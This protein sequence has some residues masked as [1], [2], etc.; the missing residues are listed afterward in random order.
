MAWLA[1]A[2]LPSLAACGHSEGVASGAG[3]EVKLDEGV[4]HSFENVAGRRNYLLQI[5]A[6]SGGDAASHLPLVIY[7]HGCGRTVETAVIST[8]WSALAQEKGF[9][10]VYPEQTDSGC[11]T[12]SD[13]AH[14]HRDVGEPSIIAGITQE[15]MAQ[16][17]I[18]P[19]RVFVVGTSAGGYMA[20]IMGVTYPEL[21]A[22]V[23]ILAGGPYG[24]GSNSEPDA[25]GSLSYAEMGPRAR[26]MPVFIAQSAND[27][28]NPAGAAELALQQWLG[29]ADHADDSS[30]NESVSRTP[31]RQENRMPEQP[32][33]PGSG[34][35]CLSSPPNVCPGGA[36]GFQ[37]HYPY[38]VRYYLDAL[39]QPLI[40]FW[41]VYG[42]TH[43]YASGDDPLG[44][45]LTPAVYDFLLQHPLEAVG[46]A[47][48]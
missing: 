9:A 31:D 24:L 5:P 30:A 18:D 13:A 12:W 7:L 38:T 23:G 1:V 44:P 34:D 22:A 21:Y 32:P 42:P 39:S 2:M 8:G 29:L 43:T 10:V 14:Q 40:E 33:Q 4:W 15:V 19:A 27:Q 36:V 11:W 17:P 20:N 46:D 35:P 45:D 37:E 25:T 48:R 3:A 47:S 16:H 6:S 41:L 28:I 26:V